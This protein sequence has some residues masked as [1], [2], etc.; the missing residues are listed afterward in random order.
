MNHVQICPSDLNLCGINVDFWFILK[1]ERFWRKQPIKA[2][3]FRYLL[4]L[5]Q[6][7]KSIVSPVFCFLLL[8]LQETG[9]DIFQSFPAALW[10][11]RRRNDS[12]IEIMLP[13]GFYRYMMIV[14]LREE[15]DD[16]V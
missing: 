13:H 3:F 6:T 11:K 5:E 16:R 14:F 12:L 1:V 2:T 15:Q 7:K 10:T 9:T 4:S 8:W